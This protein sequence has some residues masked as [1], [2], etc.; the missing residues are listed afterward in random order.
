MTRLNL[1]ELDRLEKRIQELKDE[2]AGISE[3]RW[4]AALSRDEKTLLKTRIKASEKALDNCEAIANYLQNFSSPLSKYILTTSQSARN[5]LETIKR[6]GTEQE[7]H[8]WVKTQLV[9]PTQMSERLGH[10]AASSLRKALGEDLEFH[11]WSRRT[12]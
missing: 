7:L 12:G 11:R 6:K 4:R 5:S 1:A 3:E 10:L 2:L 8:K 9:P